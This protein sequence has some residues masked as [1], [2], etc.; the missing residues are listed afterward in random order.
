MPTFDWNLNDFQQVYVGTY[1]QFFFQKGHALTTKHIQT[2]SL[3]SS[4][5][6]LILKVDVKYS[7]YL[8][9]VFLYLICK[10]KMGS[11]LSGFHIFE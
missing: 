11:F 3:V 7:I 10:I 4:P 6:V 9:Y 2:N 8:L 5:Y 1:T